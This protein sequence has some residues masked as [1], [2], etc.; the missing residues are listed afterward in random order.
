MAVLGVYFEHLY[1]T[2]NDVG[3]R[4]INPGAP[5]QF[6]VSNPPSS[7]TFA[8]SLD[9]PMTPAMSRYLQFTDSFSSLELTSP[10]KLNVRSL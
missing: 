5:G 4:H 7:L 2:V 3:K 6:V 8:L 1:T 9:R 10:T